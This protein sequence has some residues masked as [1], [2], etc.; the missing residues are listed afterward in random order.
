MSCCL[1]VGKFFSVHNASLRFVPEMIRVL[2]FSLAEL[3][4][5]LFSIQL[6]ES[7]FEQ[8]C[9]TPVHE[10]R[11]CVKD[12]WGINPGPHACL[13]TCIELYPL[14]GSSESVMLCLQNLGCNL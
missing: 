1:N 2:F 3:K 10:Q 13:H 9:A 14:P 11:C 6:E 12:T 8:I 7:N 5:K 4:G